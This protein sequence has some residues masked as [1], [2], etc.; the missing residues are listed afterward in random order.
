MPDSRPEPA[1]ADR[2]DRQANNH[3][4]HDGH[5]STERLALA[6]Q[7]LCPVVHTA[8]Q[9]CSGVFTTKLSANGKQTGAVRVERTVPV[10]YIAEG[11]DIGVDNISAVSPDYTSPFPFGGTVRSVTIAVEK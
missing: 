1:D 7:I 10:S 5:F 8:R 11:L 3:D 4:P 2:A 9:A 6:G